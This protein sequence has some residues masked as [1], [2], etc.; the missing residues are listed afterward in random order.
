M[1]Q[2]IEHSSQTI[3]QKINEKLNQG[4]LSSERGVGS[5][6]S[7]RD[8]HPGH[9]DRCEN[10][11]HESIWVHASTVQGT[12]IW[13][14]CTS[15][16]MTTWLRSGNT[17]LGGL[18]ATEKWLY[19][20]TLFPLHHELG[21]D[22]FELKNSL[23]TRHSQKRHDVRTRVKHHFTSTYFKIKRLRLNVALLI[24]I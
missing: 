9:P 2:Q 14:A 10:R 16:G 3:N 6:T 17:F 18:A 21:P 15:E 12:Q 22:S 24:L 13:S 5:Q 7:Q 19:S 4:T 23:M 11:F 8:S 1:K 20:T